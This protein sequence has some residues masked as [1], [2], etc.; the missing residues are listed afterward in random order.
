MVYVDMKNKVV[1]IEGRGFGLANCTLHW[2]NAGLWSQ[3]FDIQASLQV[4]RKCPV[5][6]SNITIRECI[7]HDS[8]VRKSS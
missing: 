1:V 3:R 4:V 2:Q 5:V 8:V 6:V 7:A